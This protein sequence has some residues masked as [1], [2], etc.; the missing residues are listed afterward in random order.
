MSLVLLVCI[1]HKKICDVLVLIH[2]YELFLIQAH[3]TQKHLLLSDGFAKI[4]TISHLTKSPRRNLQENPE[5]HLKA[6]LAA[7]GQTLSRTPVFRLRMQRYKQYF[8]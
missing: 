5:N 3:Q 8:I 2:V 6:P 7:A 4:Q 1:H